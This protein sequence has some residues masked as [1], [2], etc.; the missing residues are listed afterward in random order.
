VSQANAELRALLS[1]YTRMQADD[2]VLAEQA[3]PAY[4]FG[5]K[6]S[7]RDNGV[8]LAALK[9]PNVHLV[10]EPI[11]E[12]T[13]TGVRTKD[14]KDH[15]VDVV[16]YGTGF[17]AS[18]FLAPMKFKGSGGRDLH[19]QWAGDSRAYLGITVPN[20]PNLFVMYG[21]NTNIVV[22]GSIIFFSECEIQYIVGCIET[23]LGDGYAAMEPRQDVH[24]AFNERV[25]AGNRLMAWGAPQVSSWYKNETGRVSQNWPFALVDYWNATRAPDPADFEFHR[26]VQMAGE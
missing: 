25:D 16:I 15:D 8:W 21:P 13:P 23:L 5:G 1:E 26:A 18:D 3:I 24:D 22:N 9:R 2:P 6:R 14:G 12:I 19:A 10:T 17:T 7:V 4:P 11:A 20:F